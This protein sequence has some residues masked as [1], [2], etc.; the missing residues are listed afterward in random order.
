MDKF[1][2]QNLIDYGPRALKRPA[3]QATNSAS[4]TVALYLREIGKIPLLTADEEKKLSRRVQKG[5]DKARQQFIEAN[6]RLVVSIAKRYSSNKDPEA[7]LDFIQEGNLG[8]FRAVERFDPKFKTR[9][10]TYA[11]Y[12]I[13]Q[14]IQRSLMTHRTVRL[15]EN[16]MLEVRK[17]R[18]TRH[19]LYQELG[20]QPTSHELATE[21]GMKDIQLRR[22]EEVSQEIISLDQPL[23]N[24]DGEETR[25]GEL[26]EDLDSPQPEFVVGKQLQRTHVHRILASL[27]PRQQ[28][29]LD[30][31][32]GLKDGEPKTLEQIGQQFSISRERVRQIQNDALNRLRSQKHTMARLR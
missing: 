3:E 11:T 29:V 28:K 31:R 30:L 18:R 5:D 15:P 24:D 2:T 12:W 9:F 19:E 26:L 14:A 7:L 4:S 25:F 20:R 22:L 17:M 16:I 21:M 32:F 10:S 27:P 6:L 13:R 23:K 1:K 8:L